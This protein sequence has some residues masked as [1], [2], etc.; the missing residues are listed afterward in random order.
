M[1]TVDRVC[2]RTTGRVEVVGCWEGVNLSIWWFSD[3]E[4][5][6]S[7]RRGTDQ[8]AEHPLTCG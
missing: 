8:I 1:S 3:C 4:F 7:T 2:G 6:F 5:V